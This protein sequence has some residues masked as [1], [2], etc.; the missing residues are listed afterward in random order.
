MLAVVA[1]YDAR[2]GQITV[3]FRGRPTEPREMQTLYQLILS[4]FGR[5]ASTNGEQEIYISN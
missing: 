1:V 2:D 4:T 5:P 3:T